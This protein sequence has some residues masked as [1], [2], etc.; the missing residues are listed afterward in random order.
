M[1]LLSNKNHHLLFISSFLAF[2]ILSML[3]AVGPAIVM[4]QGT[5]PLVGE[6]KM[7]T[8]QSRGF[9]IYV[10]ENCAV[11]HTQ[12]VRPLKMDSVFGR[13]STPSDYAGIKPLS[14]WIMAPNVLG[15][16]R[17]GPDLANV[18]ERRNNDMWNYLHLYEPRAVVKESIMPSFKWLFKAVEKVDSTDIV[19]TVPEQFKTQG[20]TIVA[21][22]E[23]LDLV[24]YLNYLNQHPLKEHEPGQSTI[25][26]EYS[27]AKII[28]GI[29][30]IKNSNLDKQVSRDF[31]NHQI[32]VFEYVII[33]ISI[34]VVLL[35]FV[36]LIKTL[37][38][39]GEK[40][41]SHI[42]HKVLKHE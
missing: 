27:G 26:T 4:D 13:P 7:T 39:P 11:C 28:S 17:I 1:K 15:T 6:Q 3:I 36:F 35:A 12:Q 16:A 20:R 23:A 30:D 5:K 33:S 32:T 14:A 29:Y 38:W 40:Q 22:Q 31:Q 41:E 42:K 2:F 25:K 9:N 34:L 37:F 8:E 21:T 24:A 19:V 10:R 18:G